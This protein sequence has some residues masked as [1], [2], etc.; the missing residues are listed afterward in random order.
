MAYLEHICLW[1]APHSHNCFT[2]GLLSAHCSEQQLAEMCKARWLLLTATVFENSTIP[3]G[4]Y[5][6]SSPSLLCAHSVPGM[7]YAIGKL[8]FVAFS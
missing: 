2:P 6:N 1:F 3:P 7:G 4:G 5:N 8:D